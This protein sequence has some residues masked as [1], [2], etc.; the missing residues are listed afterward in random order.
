MNEI[1]KIH[2]G[3]QSFTISV[4]AHR[5]LKSYL[6]AVQKQVGDPEVVDEI[7][8][9]IAELLLE[10]GIAEDKVVLPKDVEY[11]QEQLGQPEDFGEED[12]DKDKVSS[13]S[14]RGDKRLFRDTDNALIAGVA[15]GLANY[16]GLDVVLVRLAIAVITIFSFGT[17]IVLYLL[18]WLVVPPANSASEKLQMRGEPVTLE[19]LKGS[20]SKADVAKTARRI[21]SSLLTVL[22]TIFRV[23]IKLIGVGFILLGLATLVGAAVTRIYMS[24]HDGKLIQEN[25]FP[26]GGRE[27]LLVWVTMGLAVL[28]SVFLI[29]VGLAI[30][31]RKW[32]LNGWVTG[33]L[34]AIFLVG[35]ITTTALAADAAPRVNERYQALQHTTAVKDIRPF[36]KVVTSGDVDISYISSPTYAANIHY[37]DHPDL[38]KVKVYVAN[39]TLYIDSRQLDNVQHCTMLCLFPRYNMTV[40]I[41]APNVQSFDTPRHTDIFYPDA[42]PPPVPV[43]K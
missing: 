39:K 8:L 25:L 29:L 12:G 26:V 11:I 15:A 13:A 14:E 9:R 6:A 20:V 33:V 36:N 24:L 19:A 10:R 22:D 4:E 31:R 38:S 35:A 23:C 40:Q 1:V 43:L 2:L 37:V 16:F 7:E 41:Y 42:V 34:A 30:F 18:L 3:R 17:A 28:V 21:N 32:P 5:L 27:Q